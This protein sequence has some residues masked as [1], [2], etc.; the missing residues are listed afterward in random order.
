MIKSEQLFV[1]FGNYLLSDERNN[2]RSEEWS[3]DCVTHADYMNFMFKK[4]QAR[5]KRNA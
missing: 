3:L 4:N 1:A 2:G 5:G